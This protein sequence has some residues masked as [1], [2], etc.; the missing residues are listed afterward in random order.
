MNKYL[1]EIGYQGYNILLI[2]I[3]LA[4]AYN[5]VTN[6]FIYAAVIAW[7]ILNHLLNVTIKNI[8]RAP[9]PDSNPEEFAKIKNSVSLNNYLT[10]HK[11]FGMPS[12]HA[13]AVVSELVFIMLYFNK[14]I[15]T[16]VA[17]LQAGL[18]IWQRYETRRHSIPQLIAGSALGI[19]V[20]LAFY[21]VIKYNKTL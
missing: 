9:R 16:A 5:H 12:G 8:L 6:P 13:Q 20:G 21:T 10:I 17:A 19:I 3:L 14:P 1:S 15:L 2:L 4:L 11:H 7:Q 18:T